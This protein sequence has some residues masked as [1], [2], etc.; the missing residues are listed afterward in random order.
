MSGQPL[1]TYIH[2]FNAVQLLLEFDGVDRLMKIDRLTEFD[3]YLDV[4]LALLV[5]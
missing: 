2:L 1:K 5:S 3:I 4:F